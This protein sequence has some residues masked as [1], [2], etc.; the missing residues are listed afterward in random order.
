MGEVRQMS[1]LISREDAIKVV[2]EHFYEALYKEPTETD[3]DGDKVFADMKSVNKLLTHNKTISKALKALPSAELTLQTPQ[4]YGKSINP[5]NAEVV[6]DYI[7]SMLVYLNIQVD[8]FHYLMIRMKSS[9]Q[10]RL[11]IGVSRILKLANVPKK[12]ILIF[13]QVLMLIAPGMKFVGSQQ[14]R[15]F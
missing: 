8:I 6:E 5:S 13:P 12:T 4:I 10:C 14:T 1:D 3:E 15:C 9:Q 11:S 7:M 2:H